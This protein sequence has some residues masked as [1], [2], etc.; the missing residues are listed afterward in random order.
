MT[1]QLDIQGGPRGIWEV[2]LGAWVDSLGS[3]LE[4]PQQVWKWELQRHPR[5]GSWGWLPMVTTQQ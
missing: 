5:V 1:L 3:G 4:S 2:K